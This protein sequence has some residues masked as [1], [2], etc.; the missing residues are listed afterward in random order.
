MSVILGLMILGRSKGM[1]DVYVPRCT[2]ENPMAMLDYFHGPSA[3]PKRFVQGLMLGLVASNYTPNLISVGMICI[4]LP[5]M[6]WQARKS[7]IKSQRL[8]YTKQIRH[9]NM[10]FS[11]IFRCLPTFRKLWVLRRG[12]PAWL[13]SWVGRFGE[14]NTLQG[15]VK[16][17]AS[18]SLEIHRFMVK[19]H[20]FPC[21]LYQNGHQK[22]RVWKRPGPLKPGKNSPDFCRLSFLG[23]P[24][25]IQQIPWIIIF[26][27]I[28]SPSPRW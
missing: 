20:G 23:T 27:A 9:R 4:D 10:Y 28:I 14:V 24:T 17:P 8:W 7:V 26:P 5:Q 15:N 22:S 6:C 13:Y 21:F 18:S 2:M 1:R 19:N 25:S 12:S 16:D 11:D 3:L